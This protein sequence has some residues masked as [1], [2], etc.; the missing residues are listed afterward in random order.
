[1]W[2][3]QPSAATL[4]RRGV[5]CRRGI[6]DGPDETRGRRRD[7]DGLLRE[8]AEMPG[9]PTRR[10]LPVLFVLATIALVAGLAASVA[11][12]A[13]PDTKQMVL[14]LTDLPA[15]FSLDKSYYADNARAVKEGGGVTLADYM[16]W[17]RITGYE[18]DFSRE[19]LAGIIS[20]TTN[21]STYKTAAGAAAST[22]ASY[23]VAAKTKRIYGKL[24]S[25]KRVSTGAKI[26]HE[27]RMF[28]TK[29]TSEGIAV[30]VYVL[31]WR[32]RTVKAALFVGGLA[33]TLDAA[34]VVRLAQKQQ[35]RIAAA[36]S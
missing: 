8:G 2:N 18:A 36:L 27:A 4:L 20:L 25:F 14:R 12:A 33:G 34:E 3:G 16:R 31:I 23:A 10:A 13:P 6:R 29:V 32:Y 7:D 22:R 35:T 28:T 17:G 19:A 26:G 24:T 5:L 30:S 15:G 21:A 9:I 11:L 1:M